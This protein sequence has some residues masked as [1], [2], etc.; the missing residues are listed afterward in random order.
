MHVLV[1]TIYVYKIPEQWQIIYVLW[2]VGRR[3]TCVPC[4]RCSRPWQVH[5]HLQ[6]VMRTH[7]R[8]GL[9]LHLQSITHA[10][11]RLHAGNER[12]AF[13]EL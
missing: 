7:Q 3:V 5:E 10:S 11:P 4:S 1:Y 2:Q 8:N 13:A 12:A 6:N 9:C